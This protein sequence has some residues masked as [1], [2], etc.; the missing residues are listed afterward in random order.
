MK[1]MTTAQLSISL[2]FC[3]QISLFPPYPR[4]YRPRLVSL[5]R[6]V[7]ACLSLSGCLGLRRPLCGSKPSPTCGGLF[8]EPTSWQ[9]NRQNMAR[10][11]SQPRSR[12][13]II[14]FVILQ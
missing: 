3:S 8:E 1:A 10:F 7:C 12:E 4:P 11:T 2:Y 5:C 6:P 13:F 14:S 9:P